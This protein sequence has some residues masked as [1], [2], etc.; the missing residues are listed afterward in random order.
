MVKCVSFSFPP[1]LEK[2]LGINML[3]KLITPDGK[4][5]EKVSGKVF[6]EGVGNIA[7]FELDYLIYQDKHLSIL[8]LQKIIQK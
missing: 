3:V 7:N 4:V 1:E 2:K 8:S 6:G 5:L